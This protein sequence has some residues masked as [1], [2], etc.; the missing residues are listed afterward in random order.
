VS[1]NSVLEPTYTAY[2]QPRYYAWADVL[3]AIRR[4]KGLGVYTTVNYLV[5]P[6]VTDREEGWRPPG[7]VPRGPPTVRCGT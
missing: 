2:Y 6:G 4:A 1:L 3:E 7:V 5:F